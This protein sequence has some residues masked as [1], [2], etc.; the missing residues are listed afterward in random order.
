MI[1]QQ[2]GNGREDQS[3]ISGCLDSKLS[4]TNGNNEVGKDLTIE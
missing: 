1:F 2:V 3:G 4:V